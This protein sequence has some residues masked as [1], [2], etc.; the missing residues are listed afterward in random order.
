[1]KWLDS[2]KNSLFQRQQSKHIQQAATIVR[3]PQ[4]LAKCQTIGILLD[5]TDEAQQIPVL[6][7]AQQLRNAGKKVE[8]LG[9]FDVD[10]LAIT[11]AN[12][13]AFAR[14]QLNFAKV[15]NSEAVQQFVQQ[16]FDM[17]LALYVNA[18]PPLDYIVASSA[19]HFRVGRFEAAQADLYE[20][21]IQPSHNDA[22]TLTS[23]L[24]ELQ[25]TLNSLNIK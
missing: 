7:Y 4:A 2:I 23:Y 3:R 21:M 11:P 5:A 16:P 12:M 9:Y 13:Q 15:P 14:K 19:A 6:Q 22:F 1:M 10:D 25:H 8:I 17:L 18:C 24:H 20:L